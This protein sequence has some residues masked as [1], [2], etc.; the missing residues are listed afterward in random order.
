MLLIK[1]NNNEIMENNN[2]AIGNGDP[3]D[4]LR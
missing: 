1:R 4:F 2:L 3:D